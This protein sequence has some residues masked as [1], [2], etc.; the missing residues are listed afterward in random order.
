MVAYKS[1]GPDLGNSQMRVNL[2]LRTKASHLCYVAASWVAVLK[3]S[4]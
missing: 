4:R 2:D 3:G 1:T